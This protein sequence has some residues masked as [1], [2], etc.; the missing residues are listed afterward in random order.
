MSFEVVIILAV[1]L[2]FGIGVS[3]DVYYPKKS[4]SYNYTSSD[5]DKAGEGCMYMLF[6]PIIFIH[7]LFVR[8]KK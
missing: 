7:G 4:K 2:F 3:M 1:Y 6:F 5:T 8:G